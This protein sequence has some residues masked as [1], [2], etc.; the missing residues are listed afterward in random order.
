MMSHKKML[1]ISSIDWDFVWQRHQTFVQGFLNEG[2]DVDFLNNSYFRNPKI[3]DLQKVIKRIKRKKSNADIREEIDFGLRVITPKVMPPN[4]FAFRLINKWMKIPSL[5]KRMRPHYDLVFIYLPT[6]TTVEIMKSIK[7]DFVVFDYVA[8]FNAHPNKAKDY[9]KIEDKLLGISNIVITDSDFLYAKLKL[10]HKR[11]YQLHHGVQVKSFLDL[12][13]RLLNKYKTVCFF[14]AIDDRM[15]WHAINALI[16]HGYK[17]T[18]IGPIRTKVPKHITV[19]APLDIDELAKELRK[20]DVI[21]IP[22]L[23]TDYNDGIVPA[24]LY[25]CFALGKPVL[26]SP[27]PAMQ[28]FENVLYICN[29]PQEYV[30]IMKDLINLESYEKIVN[31][32]NLAKEQSVEENFRKLLRILETERGSYEEKNAS[33]H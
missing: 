3:A 13:V 19:K 27:L 2:W 26:T 31:R 12:N 16:D 32:Q 4:G 22:Y 29:S 25:E 15:D 10:K 17:V 23:M 28:Q 30:N 7:A 9:R 18:L 21:I 6:F 11:V 33:C 14:G 24:K 5:V 20:Y 8:N 1:C